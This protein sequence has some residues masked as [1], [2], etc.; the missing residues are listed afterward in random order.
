M[1]R[2]EYTNG[3]HSRQII[4]AWPRFRRPRPPVATNGAESDP[5]K[6]YL[7]AVRHH[8]AEQLEEIHNESASRMAQ[9]GVIGSQELA[10]KVKKASAVEIGAELPLVLLREVAQRQPHWP[11]VNADEFHNSLSRRETASGVHHIDEALGFGLFTF[12]GGEIAG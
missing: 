12:G 2:S 6:N 7:H 1:Q 11:A 5:A 8:R 4:S 3:C 9:A 10:R